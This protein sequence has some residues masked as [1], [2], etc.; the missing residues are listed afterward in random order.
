MINDREVIDEYQKELRQVEFGLARAISKSLG[1]D[2][3]F[4]EN[5]FNLK[6]GFDVSAMNLYPPNHNSKSRMNLP[7][8]TDPGFIISLLQDVDG[9]LQILSHQGKWINASIPH[10]A[11][12]IQLGDHLEEHLS[13]LYISNFNYSET[14]SQDQIINSII[15]LIT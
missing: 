13:P 1:F 7:E 6:S 9:G 12:L 11:I 2:E 14:D 3:K 5:A 15:E 8:H 4:I 10:H